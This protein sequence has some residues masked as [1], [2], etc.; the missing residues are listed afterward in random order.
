MPYNEPVLTMTGNV[1]NEP[2][3]RFTP[4]GTA[5]VNFDI[6]HNPRVRKGD[7]WVDGDPI[8]MRCT[9][10]RTLAEN[11]AD[12]VQKG[13]RVTIRGILRQTHWIDRETDENRYR[14]ECTVSDVAVSLQFVSATTNKIDRSTGEIDDNSDEQE[15]KPV[16]RKATKSNRGNGGNK[17]AAR[18][19][20][21][22]YA[23]AE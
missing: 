11:V 19:R 10:W 20:A 7:E 18:R 17:S 9:A 1:V 14:I 15:E 4:N 22:E 12:S 6:A 13:H 8:F 5:V 3:L 2:D 16:N 23:N 21:T